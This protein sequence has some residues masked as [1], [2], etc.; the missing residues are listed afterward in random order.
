MSIRFQKIIIKNFLSYGK[1][2]TTVTLER[3]GQTTFVVGEDLDDT[4]G[5]VKGNGVGKT[6][7]LNA[8]VFALYNKPISNI[9]MENL[10]NN[11]NKKD[12]EVTVEFEKDGQAYAVRRSRR[13]KQGADVALYKDKTEI[14]PDSIKLTSLKIEEIIGYPYEL[15]VRIVAYSANH[16][17]FLDLPTTHATQA[18]QKDIVEEL[19]EMK[20]LSARAETLKAEIKLTLADLKIQ[21]A[22]L[23]QLK[24]EHER[25]NK[26]VT[27]TKER[28]KNWE[29]DI[30][31][32]KIEIEQK[33][34]KTEGIDI[35]KQHKLHETLNELNQ[36]KIEAELKQSEIEKKIRKLI[37]NKT[38]Y[39]KELE[40]LRDSK[41]PY[42]K[43][44]Y[45]DNEWKI[46]DRENEID[47]TDS[48]IEKEGDA[49]AEA[50]SENDTIDVEIQTVNDQIQVSNIRELMDIRSKQA[51]YTDRIKHLEA[52]TNPHI[53][54]L[55]EL[56]DFEL[57][58]ID[59]SKI[60]ELDDELVHQQ[61]LLKTLT[62]KD[63][64][65]RKKLLNT[66]IP[67]LNQKL[68]KYL[69]IL[70]LP[71]TV[72]FTE[73]MTVTITRFGRKLDF[74]N[75]SNGQQARLN[76]ALSLAFRDMLE[77]IHGKI[78]VYMLDEVLDVGLDA[79]GITA[80]A[81]L[82]KAKARDEDL[83]VYIISHKDE[84]SNAFDSK[85]TIKMSKGFSNIEETTTESRLA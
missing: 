75:L 82:L 33:L 3:P 36:S 63:S 46:V 7:I 50:A 21:K 77:N 26:L 66:K 42:C 35:D 14:T 57:E 54:A 38:E 16:T 47:L 1:K 29:R 78:N 51:Q 48:E 53:D 5:G 24:E 32:E 84:L 31:N 9:S 39:E 73:E 11:V 22:H 49:L 70:G 27:S 30:K 4:A 67:F 18:N 79:I 8:L 64:F 20:I 34:K 23:E 10:V 60:D 43:Q 72:R 81:K 17:P 12:M 28:I 85:M 41:C 68:A 76:F 80:A 13:G 59:T 37:S 2:P 52:E 62:K 6:A 61:F 45:K 71:H 44:A 40:H 69:D 56:E 55:S 25:H 83:S 74:G 65:V 15:F 58:D 19:F